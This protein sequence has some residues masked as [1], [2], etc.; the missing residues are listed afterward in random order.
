MPNDLIP[1]SSEGAM[2]DLTTIRRLARRGM[3]CGVG[4]AACVLFTG[5]RRDPEFMRYDAAARRVGLD[6]HHGA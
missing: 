6:C 5:A 3:I 1:A 4:Y 2:S